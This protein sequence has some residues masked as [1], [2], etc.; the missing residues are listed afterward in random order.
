MSIFNFKKK[1]K[2]QTESVKD[3]DSFIQFLRNDDKELVEFGQTALVAAGEEVIHSMI[4]LLTNK[5]EDDRV[6][7]RVGVVLSRIGKPS[8]EPLLEVLKKQ[9]WESESSAKTVGMTAAALGGIGKQAVEPL[10][11][12][13]DSEL[14]AVKY[15]A[16]IALMQTGEAEAVDAV[17]NAADHGDPGDREM[18]K[19]VLGKR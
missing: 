18:F 6:R 7:R 1:E 9:N 12:A 13:L 15:G 3:P 19:M 10:I 14:R 2:T 5:K 4:M 17:R 11:K 16:A 8:I